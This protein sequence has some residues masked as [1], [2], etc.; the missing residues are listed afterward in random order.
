MQLADR[1]VWITGASDGIGAALAVALASRK[2]KLILTARREEKLRQVAERCAGATVAVLPADL[3]EGDPAELAQQAESLLGPVDVLVAN[4]GQGQRSRAL[5]TELPVVRRLMELNFFAPVALT[6]AVVPGMVERGRGRVVVT[7]SLAG[8]IGTPMRSSYAASK[9]AVE[10]YFESLRAELHGTGVGV[11]VIAPGYVDTAISTKAVSGDGSAHGKVAKGNAE[12]LSAEQC[13]ERMAR[14]L[15]RDR[16]H[17]M[18]GGRE[19]GAV[20]LK[21]W[22]PWLVRRYLHRA[23]PPDVEDAS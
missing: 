8:S 20:Y 17:V 19:V 2:A 4:A 3:L 1:V 7:S 5:D 16:D 12:G 22:A 21:R 18:I 13:A 23:A 10:G 9:H 6:R 14:A 11:T 15:E